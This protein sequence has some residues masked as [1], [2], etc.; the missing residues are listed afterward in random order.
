MENY[1]DSCGKRNSAKQKSATLASALITARLHEKN[2]L[3]CKQPPV[4]ISNNKQIQQLNDL[5]FSPPSYEFS[6]L[7]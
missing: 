7:P 1:L 4:N 3:C 2:D 5:S 6:F